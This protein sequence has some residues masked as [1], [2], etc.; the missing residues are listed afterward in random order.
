M[1]S[2]EKTPV[3]DA[4]LKLLHQFWTERLVPAAEALRARGVRFF[5]LA[6]DAAATTYYSPAVEHDQFFTIEPENCEALLKEMWQRQQLPELAEL[7]GPLAALSK[8]LAPTADDHGD[9]SPFIY[10]MF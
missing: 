9:V 10:V 2:T 3:D 8:P 7:A 5:E 1:S 4:N 6:P